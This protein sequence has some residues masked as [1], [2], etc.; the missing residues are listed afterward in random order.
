[1]CSIINVWI[2]VKIHTMSRAQLVS[3]PFRDRLSMF[4]N[5]SYPGHRGRPSC[6]D[7]ASADAEHL[8]YIR[9]IRTGKVAQPTADRAWE[10]GS[11]LSRL[12][13]KRW[14]NSVVM[15][16]G[17]GHYEEVAAVFLRARETGLDL[18]RSIELA[19]ALPGVFSSEPSRSRR[20]F[21]NDLAFREA[22][23]WDRSLPA[24]ESLERRVWSIDGDTYAAF[25]QGWRARNTALPT[26]PGFSGLINGCSVIANHAKYPIVERDH[27]V[28]V[29]L[30]DALL[31]AAM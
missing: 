21:K 16:F 6:V 28:A 8:E 1:M 31:G 3:R 2:Y 11:A 15:I 5:D 17:C 25:A 19:R 10:V 20:S 4:L 27:H 23:N 29:L 7:E 26:A 9:Q 18:A 14:L 24:T 22:Q 12:S 13:G 30:V